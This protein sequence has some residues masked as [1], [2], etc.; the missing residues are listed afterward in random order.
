[1]H[2]C[3]IRAYEILT[4]RVPSSP[5]AAQPGAGE[6]QRRKRK[7][8][9]QRTCGPCRSAQRSSAT[10]RPCAIHAL[11]ATALSFACIKRPSKRI[12][13]GSFTETLDPRKWYD[14]HKSR[15]E[16][17]Q[18]T[19]HS[20]VLEGNR[21]LLGSVC[22]WHQNLPLAVARSCLSYLITFLTY[23]TKSNSRLLHLNSFT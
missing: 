20:F 1:M 9:W 17:T 8:P 21:L 23:P 18:T 6:I 3:E 22:S 4:A 11:T 13:A 16:K 15:V 10:T 19:G 12:Y 14:S 7:A 5:A 2:A